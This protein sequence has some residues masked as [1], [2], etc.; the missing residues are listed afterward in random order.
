[1]IAQQPVHITPAIDRLDRDEPKLGYPLHKERDFVQLEPL[2][3]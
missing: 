2:K 1:M 3:S